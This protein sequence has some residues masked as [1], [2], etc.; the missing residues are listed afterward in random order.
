MES[1]GKII[2]VTLEEAKKK[3]GKSSIGKLL[4]EQEKEKKKRP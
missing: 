3:K 2:R 1:K 4:S